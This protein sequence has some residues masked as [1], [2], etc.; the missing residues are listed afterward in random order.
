MTMVSRLIRFNRIAFTL[1]ILL[2]AVLSASATPDHFNVSGPSVVLADVGFD[3]EVTAYDGTGGIDTSYHGT[4]S[5]EGVLPGPAGIVFASGKALLSGV[6]VDESG[7]VEVTVS[8]GPARGSLSIRAIPGLL[9]IVPPLV[10]ILFALIFREVIIALCAG[11]WIGA[12]FIYDYNPLIGLLRLVDRFVVGALADPDHAAIIV[13]TMLFGGMVGVISKN[14]GMQGIAAILTRWAR[15]PRRGQLSTWFLGVV[16]F[17][18]DYANAL[19]VGNTMRPVTDKLRISRE[20]LAY[21]VDATSAPVA[22]VFFISSWIGYEVGLIDGAIK[23]I[24]YVHENA[25]WLFIDSIAYRFYPIFALVL[26]FTIAAS[27]RDFGP[28]LSAERRARMTG[29]L[30]G[31]NARLATDLPS[32]EISVEKQKWWNG[33]L[34]IVTVVV[35]GMISLYQTGYANILE[36]GGD[37]FSLSSIIGSSDSYRALQWAALASC[38]VAIGLSVGQR[39]MSFVEALEAWVGGMKAMIFAMMILILAWSIGE[40]TVEL[41]TADYLVQILRGSLSPHFLPVLTFVVAAVISFATG[42]SWGT[43][44]ILMPLVIPLSVS[45]SQET[46]LDAAGIHVLLLGT[47]SSVL[48]GAVAGD[49]CSPISDTT[50]LSSTAASCDHIDHVRT[51]LPYALVAALV[52]MVIGDLPTAYGLPPFVSILVGSAVLIALVFVFGKQSDSPTGG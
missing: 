23:S 5:L 27:G 42:T 38:L 7:R 4:P 34:P 36:A 37:D 41:K 43:M 40:V 51:Q 9:S 33:V 25:Y 21:I 39:V 30:Y 16:I 52:G 10:A 20:K 22:S 50:I 31:D 11:V 8:E 3:I 17:F 47:V 44:G 32:V 26:G 28:M 24:G 6:H 46:G 45:L 13:F 14:G 12:I 49:H 15:S 19:I 29:K 1:L 18:D 48:A 35:V 2:S